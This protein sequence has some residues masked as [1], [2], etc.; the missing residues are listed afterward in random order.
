MKVILGKK[1]GMTQIY[2]DNGKVVP[3]T[4]VDVS[5]VKVAKQL[6]DQNG[7]HI[8][9]LAI[10]TQKNPNNADKNNYKE[11]G[12]VPRYKFAY[13]VKDSELENLKVGAEITATQFEEGDKVD[14][15]GVTKGKGFQGVM[16]RHGFKG[17]P[18]THGGKSG[19][20]RSPGSIG[21]GTTPGRVLKGKK[22]AGRMGNERQTTQNLRVV[23]V[24]GLE[25][26]IGVRGA[27]PGH[28]GSYVIIKTPA[29]M[30]RD[31]D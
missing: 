31:E 9:E 30:A 12:F 23:L 20:Y 13:H 29:K 24:D 7:N 18:K 21:S 25:N 5:G 6:E 3:V 2:A 17:G 28:R 10:D 11:L 1:I 26:V 22:M 16:K 27:V 4:L 15:I 19:K 8:V 14:V